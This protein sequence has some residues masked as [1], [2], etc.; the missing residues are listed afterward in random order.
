MFLKTGFID[1]KRGEIQ[2]R[3]IREKR[4]VGE[5]EKWRK[6]KEGKSKGG[7]NYKERWKNSYKKGKGEREIK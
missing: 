4:D 6:E 2:K 3:E 1:C 7:K 5:R